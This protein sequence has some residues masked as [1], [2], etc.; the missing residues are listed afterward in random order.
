MQINQN[1]LD[2][3]L[4]ERFSKLLFK[5]DS[6]PTEK[7]EIIQGSI[8]VRDI[9]YD[10]KEPKDYEPIKSPKM[11]FLEKILSY[12]SNNKQN[13]EERKIDDIKERVY[14]HTREYCE[15]ERKKTWDALHRIYDPKEA[16]RFFEKIY[17]PN[18][19]ALREINLFSK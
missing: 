17:K 6:N 18:E 10:S 15:N 9:L 8:L 16:A 1:I 7:L 11:S 12:F 4:T 19:R 14:R 2:R 3:E 5:D 13:V